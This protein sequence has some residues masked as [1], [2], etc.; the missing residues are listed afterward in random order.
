MLLIEN[1]NGVNSFIVYALMNV[2]K[3]FPGIYNKMLS[4]LILFKDTNNIKIVKHKNLK[5]FFIMYS[6]L[7][8]HTTLEALKNKSNSSY[9]NINILLG[10][11]ILFIQ[12]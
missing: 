6:P 3:F 10:N 2:N 12:L 11:D 8:L 7:L 4:N 5:Y 9:P 1:M